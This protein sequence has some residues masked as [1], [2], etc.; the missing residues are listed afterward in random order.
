MEYQIDKSKMVCNE[1]EYLKKWIIFA[2]DIVDSEMQVNKAILL[3]QF[4]LYTLS[5]LIKQID[6]PMK[7]IGL[8]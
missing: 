4:K 7:N 2:R 8:M 5:D 1:K 6:S 3:C